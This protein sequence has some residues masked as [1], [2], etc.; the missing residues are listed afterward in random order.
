MTSICTT[1]LTWRIPFSFKR[2]GL[3]YVSY[4][5]ILAAASLSTPLYLNLTPCTSST[6]EKLS[7]DNCPLCLVQS[8][9]KRWKSKLRWLLLRRLVRLKMP[10]KPRDLNSSMSSTITSATR[11]KTLSSNCCQ[12]KISLKLRSKAL[13]FKKISEKKVRPWNQGGH[14]KS[15][16]RKPVKIIDLPRGQF[17]LP[18]SP[19]S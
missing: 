13:M 2:A 18:P 15:N 12:L 8:Q 19:L 14:R 10:N 3:W 16:V 11:G 17:T 4:T 5:L 6:F 7:P 1:Y 9:T